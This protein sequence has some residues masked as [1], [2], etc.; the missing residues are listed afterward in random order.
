M[1]TLCCGRF[2]FCGCKVDACTCVCPF[3]DCNKCIK[4]DSS[5]SEK[6]SSIKVIGMTMKI[7]L[8]ETCGLSI[9]FKSLKYSDDT[10][11]D[12]KL[13]NDEFIE[14]RKKFQK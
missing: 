2:P 1:N 7:N 5:L 12:I 11:E 4:K 9:F 10:D 13:S 6:D 3:I 14:W 8:C